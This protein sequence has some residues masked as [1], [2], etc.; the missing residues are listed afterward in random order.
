MSLIA[1]TDL[2]TY[3][4]IGLVAVA[5]VVVVVVALLL[6][7]IAG[8]RRI[9]AAAGRALAAVERIQG[10]T[11]PLWDL[12]TTNRVAGELLAGAGSIKRHAELL[13]SALEAT[14][15]GE[16]REARR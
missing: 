14:E 2:Q 15:H 8:A 11:D 1:D 9:L 12:T 5:L 10:N 16:R 7:I 3:W 4:V 6:A 13:A